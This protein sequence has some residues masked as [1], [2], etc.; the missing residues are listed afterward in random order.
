MG[1]ITISVFRKTTL[2]ARGFIGNHDIVGRKPGEAFRIVNGKDFPEGLAQP[3]VDDHVGITLTTTAIG[4]IRDN[5]ARPFFLYFTPCVP[6]TH[7]TPA[8]EFR[9]TSQAGLLGDNLQE[10]DAQSER[11]PY[12][13][14]RSIGCIRGPSPTHRVLGPR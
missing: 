2:L 1:L 6:H 12:V 13:V 11:F 9:G 3:R 7:V 14:A 10:L 4:F 5:A 8:T